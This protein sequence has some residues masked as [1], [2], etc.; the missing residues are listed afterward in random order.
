MLEL[1]E[2]DIMQASYLLKGRGFAN[3]N[4]ASK[5]FIITYTPDGAQALL[6][7]VLLDEGKEK[8]KTN[9][10]R[11]AQI[12]G[13]LVASAISINTFIL[14][15][16]NTRNNSKNIKDLKLEIDHLKKELEIQN[17]RTDKFFPEKKTY[18][19]AK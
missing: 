7:R 4:R 2:N 10:L 15:I 1:N 16:L 13:I 12:V 11:W 3:V 18:K 6:Q 9:L 19:V 14:N 17:L 5:P 8:A